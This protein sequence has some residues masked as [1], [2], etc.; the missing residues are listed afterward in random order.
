M[1][2]VLNTCDNCH[3]NYTLKNSALLKLDS[4]HFVAG[5]ARQ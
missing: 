3:D 1:L 4:R 2:H 5:E